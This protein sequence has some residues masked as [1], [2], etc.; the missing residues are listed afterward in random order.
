MILGDF[1]AVELWGDAFRRCPGVGRSTFEAFAT[2]CRWFKCPLKDN[3]KKSAAPCIWQRLAGA[4]KSVV[5]S[6][7]R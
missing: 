2:S 7:Q 5:R 6:G 3:E 1:G 4:A